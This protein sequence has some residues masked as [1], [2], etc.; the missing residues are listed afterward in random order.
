MNSN[1]NWINDKG[2]KGLWTSRTRTQIT[3]QLIE[4][5]RIITIYK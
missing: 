4:G 5:K 3:K 2:K 1:I